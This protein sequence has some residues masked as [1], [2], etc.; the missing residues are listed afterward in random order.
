MSL[1]NLR[2]FIITD[3]SKQETGGTYSTDNEQLAEENQKV[4]YTVQYNCPETTVHGTLQTHD[5][6]NKIISIHTLTYEKVYLI[7]L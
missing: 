5:I 3:F 6:F 2:N 7:L 1:L 4:G